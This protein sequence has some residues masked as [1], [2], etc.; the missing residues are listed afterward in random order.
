MRRGKG[1]GDS[2][3]RTA[4]EGLSLAVG[5]NIPSVTMHRPRSSHPSPSPP[6][7]PSHSPSACPFLPLP[8]PQAPPL[9]AYYSSDAVMHQ[10]VKPISESPRASVRCSPSFQCQQTCSRRGLDS[11]SPHPAGPCPALP[12]CQA[13]PCQALLCPALRMHRVRQGRQQTNFLFTVS[14]LCWGVV[15]MGRLRY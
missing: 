6:S 13:L 12:P 9:T 15:F 11:A 1:E 14:L 8:V 7:S 5:A 2:G 3:A 10:R 4:S